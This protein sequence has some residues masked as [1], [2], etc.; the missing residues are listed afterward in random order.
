MDKDDTFMEGSFGYDIDFL[1]KWDSNLII[2]K[3]E[4]ASVAVSGKYQAKVFTSSV[5]GN[6]GR[7]M[8]WIN[9][10]AFGKNDPHM[11]AF[12]G[13]SRLWLG[14]EG[15]A[16][17]LFFKPG[18]D[19]IF[20]NWKTPP[21]IDSEDWDVT[22]ES[23]TSV[24]F[25]RTMEIENYAGHKLNIRAQRIVKILSAEHMEE[26]LGV[27]T[28]GVKSVG[29]KTKNTI[30]NIGDFE[31]TK[32][33]GAPCIWIL[34]MFPPSEETTIFI[35]YKKE[36]AGPIATTDYFGEIAEDRIG[37]DDGIL[38]FKADGKSRGKLGIP[39]QRATSMAG[40]YDAHNN[41]L[42]ITLFD[43]DSDATYLNQ[44]WN[45][46]G[47]PFLG[48]AVN[49]YNDGPLEDGSQMGPFYELESVSPAAF[50]KPNESLS[51]NH[52]VFH[53]TGKKENLEQ[54]VEE[55][56]GTTLELITN[57]L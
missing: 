23:E 17:S 40:S 49:A 33:T 41:V 1:K 44:E 15:N 12:G 36:G 24:A 26:L 18:T 28:K 56:F 19:M 48:D 30:T 22:E 38:F 5:S 13:E 34:D 25:E 43:V 46:E 53:L 11:N 29:Y 50:I 14:P 47:E 45:L 57:F 9:Y 21:P 10:D 16:F 51:H 7:S 6:E 52:T 8:G 27:Q 2:L 54:I 20:E 32:S 4:N 35:P 3:S 39:P 37:Y 42:T 31:W 55:V